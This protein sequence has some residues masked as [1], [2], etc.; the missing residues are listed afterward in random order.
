M[1]RI[2][3]ALFLILFSASA[4]ADE[5]VASLPVLHTL[6]VDLPGNC[7][8]KNIEGRAYIAKK[9]VSEEYVLLK[10]GD[11]VNDSHIVELNE[12]STVLLSC[13]DNKVEKL[14]SHKITEFFTFKRR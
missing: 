12:N 9:F 8:V 6:L 11:N 14:E 5:G 7:V 4:C 2:Y 10:V 13:D 3:L 1:D